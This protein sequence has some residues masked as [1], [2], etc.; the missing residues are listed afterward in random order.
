MDGEPV[1]MRS[2]QDAVRLGIGYVPEDR[3]RQGLVLEMS[4]RDNIALSVTPG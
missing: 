1:T 3:K 4:I 2:P